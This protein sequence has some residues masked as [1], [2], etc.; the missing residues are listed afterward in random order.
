MQG[1]GFSTRL[2]VRFTSNRDRL[3]VIVLLL[4]LLAEGLAAGPVRR[5]FF[6][7]SQPDGSVFEACLQGDEYGHLLTTR[8]GCAL[9]RDSEG[10]YCYAYFTPDGQRWSSGCPVGLHPVPERVLRQSRAIPRTALAARSALRRA[11]VRKERALRTKAGEELPAR[12]LVPVILA[13]YP[14]LKYTHTRADFARQFDPV[15]ARSAAAWFRDQFGDNLSISFEV[16]DTVT[17]FHNHDWYARTEERM[18]RLIADACTALAD[19]AD[20][21]RYDL[22]GNGEVDALHVIFAGGDQA[23]GAGEDHLWSHQH[24]LKDGAGI[25]L[26]LNGTRINAYSCSAELDVFQGRDELMGIG[27]FCHEFSHHFGLPDLYD[28]DYEGSGGL[29]QA[30]WGSGALMDK[31]NANGGGKLPPNYSAIERYLL[32][33]AWGFPEGRPLVPGS[34][35]LSAGKDFL[36]LESGTKDEFFLFECRD[37]SDWDAGIGGAGLAVYHIDRSLSPSGATDRYAKEYPNGLSAAQRWELNEV[38]CRPDRQCA[39]WVEADPAA[40][41]ISGIFFP[42]EGRNTLSPDSDPPLRSWSGE[43]LPYALSDIRFDGTQVHFTLKRVSTLPPSVLQ[44]RQDIYQDAAILQWEASEPDWTQPAILRWGPVGETLQSLEIEAYAPGKYAFT[45]DGLTPRTAYTVEILFR[46]NQA[47][48]TLYRSSFTTKPIY[49]NTVPFISLFGI[50]R[51]EDGRSFPAGT[52]LPLRCN[53]LRDAA[54]VIWTLNGQGIAPGPDGYY[55]IGES[56]TLRAVIHYR[57]GTSD[58]LEKKMMV[59]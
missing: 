12:R 34:Y 52:A 56:G 27:A 28:T 8:D 45:C 26:S 40:T 43:D 32:G 19:K 17:V 55:R 5:R 16:F 58:I 22:D 24:Y 41:R 44:M 15:Q 42:Q 1:L 10:F 3:L 23:D 14:D 46:R 25:E 35:S 4:F 33:P 51:G 13:Q 47:D 18:Y 37:G 21:S 48:G 59:R 29:A 38:N 31:G 54:E 49:S 39:D 7:L 6:P 9:I 20:F 36:L 57:D 2:G 53:N 11:Q 50:P 30:L